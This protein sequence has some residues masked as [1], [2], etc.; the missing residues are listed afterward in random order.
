MY[1]GGLNMNMFKPLWSKHSNAR[2]AD[3]PTP[4]STEI[5]EREWYVCIYSPNKKK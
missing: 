2:G 3:M 1:L 5:S 4:D